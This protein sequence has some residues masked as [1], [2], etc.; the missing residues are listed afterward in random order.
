MV[1][2][3]I[4]RWD[5]LQWVNL[6]WDSL[7]WDSLQVYTPVFLASIAFDSFQDT[8]ALHPTSRTT[9]PPRGAF[10]S[11]LT[12]ALTTVGGGNRCIMRQ[13]GYVPEEF[14]NKGP[15]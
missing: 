13:G 10:W 12:S 15:Q 14:D 11:D 3:D 5:T 4:L 7:Q 9:N 6:Q 8:V 2:W 1:W